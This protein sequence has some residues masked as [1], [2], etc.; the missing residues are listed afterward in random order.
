MRA[1]PTVPDRLLIAV[2]VMLAL[3][4]GGLL[5]EDWPMFRGNDARTGATTN[6]GPAPPVAILW[7]FATGGAVTSSPAVTG[8]VVYFGSADS[9]VYAVSAVDG[10]LTWKLQ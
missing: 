9:S 10:S 4:P 6:P 7:Q 1:M 8:D 2:A 5:A 3:A